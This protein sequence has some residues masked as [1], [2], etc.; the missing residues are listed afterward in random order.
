[1]PII[2]RGFLSGFQS[3]TNSEKNGAGYLKNG[4][5]Y[6]RMLLYHRSEIIDST[7]G[8]IEGFKKLLYWLRLDVGLFCVPNDFNN[9]FAPNSELSV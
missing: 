3:T 1:M 9:L 5:N 7:I 2:W 8:I 4:S 6:C